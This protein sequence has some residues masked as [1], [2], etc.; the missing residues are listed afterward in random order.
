MFIVRNRSAEWEVRSEKIN[1]SLILPSER[2]GGVFPFSLWE[3]VPEE[4]MS[5]R[6][7][8]EGG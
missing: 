8:S 3:K 1:P 4:D 5:R 2:G 6:S 7:L